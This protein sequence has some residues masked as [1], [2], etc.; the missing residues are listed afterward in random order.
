MPRLTRGMTGTGGRGA[1]IPAQAEIHVSDCSIPFSSSGHSRAG[2]NPCPRH[3]SVGW[4]PPRC[5][6]CPAVSQWVSDWW[7]PACAGMTEEEAPHSE[8]GAV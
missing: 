4:H 7:I 6:L 1:V 3:A 8:K 5:H 2:G